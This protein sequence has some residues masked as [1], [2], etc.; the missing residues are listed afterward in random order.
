VFRFLALLSA[1]TLGL[2]AQTVVVAP[3]ANTSSSSI[4]QVSN[5]D[6][7]G[8]SIAETLREALASRGLLVL[9]RD[10]VQEGYR[11]LRLRARAE[12]TDASILK[13]GEALD[14]EQILFGTFS[15]TPAP[16]NAP[17]DTKG[18]L[19][20]SGRLIDRKALRQSPEFVE[21]GALEDLP[22]LES[23]LAWRA[24]T[25]VD[26]KLAPS[27]AE[28]RALRPPIRLDAEENYIRGLLTASP[29]RREKYFLQAARLDPAFTRPC[30]QL[31]KILYHRKQFSEAAGWLEK[32]GAADVHYR[33]ASFVLGLSRYELG[34]FAAAQKLF[35]MIS[36]VIPLG[37][38][39]NNL[40]AAENRRNLPQAVDDFRKA[41]EADPN[42]PAYHFNLG[43]AL[44]KR[45]DFTAAADRFRAVLDRSAD[46][47]MA[48]L[49]LGRCLKKLGPR[50]GDRTPLE[51]RLLTLER[52]KTNYEERAYRQLKSM[53]E[54]QDK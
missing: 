31:G 27:E 52:I 40:A 38:V 46:D 15:F 29:E 11:R 48:T 18:S 1:S 16:P 50:N 43:Y 39:F 26:A 33:E 4:P 36:D 45:G 25:L 44:W 5:L 3:F 21:T 17:P 6:W 47:Q 14:S 42:D 22:T 51:V 28:F 24:L 23:H 19:K 7:I 34:D 10:D 32:V 41:L 30:F 8:E 49:L 20:I 13:L 9:E 53:L 54:A 2:T 12:L 35:Q 37:E